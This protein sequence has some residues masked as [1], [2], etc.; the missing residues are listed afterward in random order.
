ME[1]IFVNTIMNIGYSADKHSNGD[2]DVLIV[3]TVM[4]SAT[5]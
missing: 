1:K 2:T 4:F 3:E 5:Y